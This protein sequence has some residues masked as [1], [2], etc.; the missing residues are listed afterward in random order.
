ML[1]ESGA[2]GPR[3]NQPRRGSNAS[4]GDFSLFALWA[5]VRARAAALVLFIAGE[6]RT[7]RGAPSGTN[8]GR[9]DVARGGQFTGATH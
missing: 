6:A 7:D 2:P 3:E 9:A 8:S 4:F 5:V 1:P